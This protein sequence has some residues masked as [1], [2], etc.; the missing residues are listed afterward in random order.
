MKVAILTLPLNINYGGVLQAYA[1]QTTL[2][3]MGHEV[4]ILDKEK[5]W[6]QPLWRVPFS[7]LKR[8]ILKIITRGQSVIF[9][10]RYWNRVYPLISVNIN[11]FINQ[12]LHIR[13]VD[14]NDFN[15]IKESDYDAII[16]GSDQIW[17]PKYFGKTI[18]NAFLAFTNNWE[19]KR[20]S[21]AASFGTSAW[22][23][24]KH[25]TKQCAKLIRDFDAVSVR[26]FHG[27]DLCKKYFNVD[28]QWVLDPTML[29]NE[30]DYT[31]LINQDELQSKSGDIFYYIL[32][33][34]DDKLSLLQLLE[35]ELNLKGFRIKVQSASA[36][37]FDV[38]PPVEVWIKSFIDARYVVTDSFHA[39]VFA[40]LFNKPFIVYGNKERGL[41]RIESLLKDFNLDHRLIYSSSDWSVL[42]EPLPST[43]TNDLENKRTKSLKF[44][45]DSLKH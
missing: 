13:I 32:D 24:S 44:L 1:L 38:Q 18:E 45:G 19:I 26:E 29:L 37:S 10:E 6:K 11:K 3:R 12:Y 5:K 2:E 20:V 17:R 42:L 15:D 9:F 22:E 36:G 16:V 25:A 21:Y 27:I 14:F 8:L 34:T 7:L 40:I 39:C 35:K 23:Y 31:N 30:N 41:S 43:L 33:E 4:T 28:A